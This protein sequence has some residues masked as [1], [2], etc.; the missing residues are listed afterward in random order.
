[1]EG[2]LAGG[3]HL[4]RAA[5]RAIDLRFHA[6]I[7]F[8]ASAAR[9]A[10][11]FIRALVIL[12]MIILCLSAVITFGAVVRFVALDVNRAS[13]SGSSTA[14][15]LTPRAPAIGPNVSGPNFYGLARDIPKIRDTSQNG[16]NFI[17]A[18]RLAVVHVAHS[19]A[20][21]CSAGASRGGY[22]AR[23]SASVNC[24]NRAARGVASTIHEYGVQMP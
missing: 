3:C 17:V 24:L 15:N 18:A 20:S 1:M 6:G 14:M 4:A 11:F 21:C 10:S 13:V 5:L 16:G 9:P 22:I 7:C 2:A 8:R 12:T 23:S 19:A